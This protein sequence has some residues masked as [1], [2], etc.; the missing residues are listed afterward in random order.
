RE[1]GA[2]TAPAGV[3]YTGVSG[4]D[5]QAIGLKLPYSISRVAWTKLSPNTLLMIS[6]SFIRP[7]APDAA[8]R[9]W[10]CA[11]Y[12]SAAGQPDVARQLAEEAAESKPQYRDQIALLLP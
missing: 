6:S 8:D 1:A 12:G 10:L 5:N 7:S 2:V 11:I 9:Q 3:E 4:A